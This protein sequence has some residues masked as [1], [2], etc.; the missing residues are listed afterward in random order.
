MTGRLFEPVCTFLE[1]TE[2]LPPPAWLIE[3]LIPDAGTC[4]AV[5]QPNTGK[6]FL[7]LHVART[8][9]TAGRAVYVV[10]EE[11]TAR[12][13]GDRFRALCFAPGAPVHVAHRRGVRLS[14]QKA[15]EQLAE[16]MRSAPAPVLI[17]DPFTSVFGGADENDTPS[18]AAARD[19]LDE[20]TAA[21]PRALLFVTH[22]V[23]K[24]ADVRSLDAV[25]G[26]TVLAAWADTVLGLE[27]EAVARGAGAV[28]FLVHVTKQREGERGHSRPVRID[29]R[30]E[31]DGFV[32]L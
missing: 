20:L 24:G 23:A 11:G 25:R 3:G 9:A 14:D 29:L 10:L 28:A 15:V 32:P 7:A 18:M 6:T 12:A 19:R 16:A 31:G 22:H 2:K 27:H 4:L 8:A 30:G 1:R 13:T 26:S 17:L 21:N 5:A